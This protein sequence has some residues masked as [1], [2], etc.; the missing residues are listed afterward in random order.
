MTLQFPDCLASKFI[1]EVW[2]LD[3]GEDRQV[4]AL[5]TRWEDRIAS[6]TSFDEKS[7]MYLF[8]DG[9]VLADGFNDLPIIADANMAK[10]ALKQ[11]GW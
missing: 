5:L 4:E 9:S 8:Q 7:Y 1:L 6:Y 10:Q 3:R 11:L 2:D